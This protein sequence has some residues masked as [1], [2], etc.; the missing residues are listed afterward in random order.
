MT[1]TASPAPTRAE[2]RCQITGNLCGTDTWEKDSPCSCGPCR[3]WL[4]Q[5]AISAPDTS[6]EV[7]ELIA[8]RLR[9]RCFDGAASTL[10]ALLDRA[11]AADRLLSK[12]KNDNNTEM[13]QRLRRDF[14]EQVERAEAAERRVAE[15]EANRAHW[16]DRAITAEAALA[17][18]EGSQ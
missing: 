4:S 14:R 11:E 2:F 13:V 16:H 9:V 17:K 3:E 6:R 15:Y 8:F 1:T 12:L 5:Q 18:A 10:L 7:V